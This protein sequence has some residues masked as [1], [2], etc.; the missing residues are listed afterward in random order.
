MIKT[1]PFH[2]LVSAWEVLFSQGEYLFPGKEVLGEYL[3]PGKEVLGEYLFPRKE[4]LG[5]Y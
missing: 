1:I 5:E 2:P 4:V 3:F